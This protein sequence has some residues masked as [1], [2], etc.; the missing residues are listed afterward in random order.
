LNYQANKT[1]SNQKKDFLMKQP[2]IQFSAEDKQD[3]ATELREKVKEYFSGNRISKFGNTALMIKAL[4]MLS[5]Y[6]VPYILLVSGVINSIP[7]IMMLW[8]L[9]GLGMAGIG[10]G[11]MHDANHGAFSVHPG[12][13]RLMS[14]TLY[15]LGG[16]PKAWQYQHN[17]LHHGFTN[18]EGL[19][20]DINPVEILR[21]SPHKPLKKIH[22]FQYIY[23]WFFYGLMTIAF[24][25]TNDFYFIRRQKRLNVKTGKN[26]SYSKTLTSLVISKIL[27]YALFLIL[28]MI[29]LPIPWYLTLVFFIGMHFVSGLILSTIFQ[30]AHVMPTSD[31]PLPDNDNKIPNNWLVHQFMT[32]TDYAPGSR[33]F[34]WFVGGLNHQVIHHLFPNVSHIHYR[35]IALIV[36]ET[37]QK[38]QVPYHVIDS[39]PK[40]I[41]LHIKMLKRLGR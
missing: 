4:C 22:R 25:T 7:V 21:F 1:K 40:A 39:F 3:F 32:T 17:T 6:L 29:I 30:T 8:F 33:I 13:N 23:A 16:F 11:I 26:S 38:H 12:M 2:I 19:D 9:M 10:M 37:A 41:G 18:I 28:P 15:L 20:E 24:I 34:A 31:F 5:L 27:Y 35:K 36:K 14:S